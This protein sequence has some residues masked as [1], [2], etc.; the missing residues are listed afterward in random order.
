MSTTAI[1]YICDVASCVIDLLYLAL[2]LHFCHCI[3]KVEFLDGFFN[4][5]RVYMPLCWVDVSKPDRTVYALFCSLQC[6]CQM[7]WWNRCA[8]NQN[9]NKN[10]YYPKR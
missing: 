3:A 1:D 10:F 9:N 5:R 8:G 2:Y 4:E 7:L 6:K